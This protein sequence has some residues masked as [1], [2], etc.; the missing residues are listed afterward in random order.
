MGNGLEQGQNGSQMSM[1]T[2]DIRQAL[3]RS[4]YDS[5]P[6]PSLRSRAN[7]A[8]GSAPNSSRRSSFTSSE[9]VLA[10]T[11]LTITESPNEYD[12]SSGS[13]RRESLENC[14]ENEPTS[15]VFEPAE[16]EHVRRLGEGTGGAVELVKDPRSGRIMAKKVS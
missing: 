2:Q 9:D 5:S 15:P 12:Q 14:E 16:L 3:S 10:L 4:R 7:S 1:M 11:A 8:A 13:E 6:R